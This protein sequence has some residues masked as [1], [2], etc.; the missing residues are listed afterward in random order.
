M[1]LNQ[2]PTILGACSF[3]ATTTAS[4]FASVLSCLVWRALSIAEDQGGG[5][6]SAAL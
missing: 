2:Q 1:L 6:T 4:S 3:P 5:E